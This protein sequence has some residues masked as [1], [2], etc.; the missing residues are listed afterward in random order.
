MF[1]PRL[2]LKCVIR[3]QALAVSNK[4]SSPLIHYIVV[5]TNSSYYYPL[6]VS[7]STSDLRWRWRI[8]LRKNCGERL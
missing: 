4:H 3:I 1:S 2:G 6:L 8:R 5:N 7:I